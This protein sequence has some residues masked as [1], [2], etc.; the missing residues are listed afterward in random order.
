VLA[1]LLPVVRDIRRIGSAALDLCAVASGGLDAYYER[2][3]KPWDLAA[4][5]LVA[6]EAGAVVVG[7]RGEPAGEAMTVAG[8]PATVEALVK[9]LEHVRADEDDLATDSVSG[10]HPGRG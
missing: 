3:L 1:T 4:A 6:Q 2:G 8:P 9:L 7:L 10:V 5:S